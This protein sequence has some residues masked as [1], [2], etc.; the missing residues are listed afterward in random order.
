MTV[1][2]LID[3]FW[4]DSFNLCRRS[5]AKTS[6]PLRLD[7]ER[8]K[9]F[10][11]LL[12][13]R[14]L[15]D[16]EKRAQPFFRR[17]VRAPFTAIRYSQ[18][19]NED[20]PPKLLIDWNALMNASCVRSERP[21]DSTSGVDDR[22]DARGTSAPTGRKPPHFRPHLLHDQRIGVRLD[23]ALSVATK[24]RLTVLMNSMRVTAGERETDAKVGAAAGKSGIGRKR[25]VVAKSLAKRPSR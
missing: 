18:V 17:C 7:G 2:C 24:M 10:R 4:N 23:L 20:C 8:V 21:R 22:V 3:N 13:L 14:S 1:R 6:F 25:H 9:P 19:K 15:L 5:R 11:R 12:L 16:A